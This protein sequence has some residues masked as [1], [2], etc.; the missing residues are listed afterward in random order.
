MIQGAKAAL[1]YINSPNRAIER[2]FQ[3]RQAMLNPM[4]MPD[5]RAGLAMSPLQLGGQLGLDSD[6]S[7]PRRTTPRYPVSGP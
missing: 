7:P 6:R 3:R 5:Y 1:N 4:P 2:L